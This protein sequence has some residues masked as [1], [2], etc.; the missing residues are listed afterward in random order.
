MHIK[1]NIAVHAKV[2]KVIAQY[3]MNV[4]MSDDPA[5]NKLADMVPPQVLDMIYDAIDAGIAEKKEGVYNG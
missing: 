3:N 4:C 2:A 5:T 1:E